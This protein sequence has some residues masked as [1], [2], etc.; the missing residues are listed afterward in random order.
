MRLGLV[1]LLSNTNFQVVDFDATKDTQA[2]SFEEASAALIIVG[3]GPDVCESSKTVAQL[4][5]GDYSAKIVVLA[6]SADVTAIRSI[7]R[8]GADGLLL[9]TTRHDALIKALELIVM[10]ER[11]FP[12]TAL[13]DVTHEI[14]QTKIAGVPVASTEQTGPHVLET[15]SDREREVLARLTKGAQDKVIARDMNLAEATVKVYVKSLLKKLGAQNRTQAAV[16]ATS[17]LA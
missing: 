1:H 8:A 11:L 15:L 13:L 10:G 3:A 5:G 14:E 7:Y 16:I 6:D 12:S 2:N 9:S 4:R 17:R